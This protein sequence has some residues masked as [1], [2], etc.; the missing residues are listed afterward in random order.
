MK[1]RILSVLLIAAMSICLFACGSKEEA[2]D[3][4][5]KEAEN[6][7]EDTE[8]V[9]AK[10]NSGNTFLAIAQD[11]GWF[12]EL[13]ITI[14]EAPFDETTAALTA[15]AGGQLDFIS[16]YGTNSPLQEIA[17]GEDFVIIGGYMAQGC[18]PIVAKKGTEWNGVEDF[19][20]KKVATDP[21]TYSFT[22]PLLEMGYDPLNEVE[23]VTYANYSDALAGVLKG[24]VDYALVGT[25][26]NYEVMQ[27]PE[28]EAIAYQSDVMPWYSCCRMVVT[29]EYAD[30]NPNT[31]KAVM[32]TL[33]RA[34]EYYTTHHDEC[35]ELMKDYMGV[36]LDYV[37]SY[38]N[39]EHFQISNDPLKHEVINAWNILDET[40][41]LSE[42]AKNINIEEHIDISFY[43][44]ALNECIEEYGDENPEFYNELK[45]FFE[46]HNL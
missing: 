13:G 3:T 14:E 40:G 42:N 6:G 19:I 34:Q 39:N 38:M 5:E 23:W 30:N 22:G 7:I 15:L 10:D 21:S 20:G 35:V 1:K 4:T 12:D 36:E 41:F 32:K 17:S 27:N 8:L 33:I 18:M 45:A 2:N 43:E 25:S 16:N 26:R 28:L 31:I 11:Q 24:E 44:E 46:E 37:E 9:W 29:K